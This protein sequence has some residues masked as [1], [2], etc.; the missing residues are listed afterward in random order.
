MQDNDK[1]LKEILKKIEVLD[2]LLESA[3]EICKE[4]NFKK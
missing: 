3:K 1:E 2:A 4:N